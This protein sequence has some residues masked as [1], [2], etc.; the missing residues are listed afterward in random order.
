MQILNSSGTLIGEVNL[1]NG[2]L[3]GEEIFI[4]E[5]GV[6]RRKKYL[7][8]GSELIKEVNFLSFDS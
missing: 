2:Q 4:N 8:K 6:I 3:N 5:A 1:L 7:G